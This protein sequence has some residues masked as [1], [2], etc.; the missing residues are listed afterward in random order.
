MADAAIRYGD[1]TAVGKLRPLLALLGDDRL[2]EQVRRGSHAA[3]E[4]LYERH[5]RG[6]LAFCRHM[7]GTAHDAEEA[8]QQ[9]FTAAY[10][11][12]TG[13]ARPEAPKPWLYG[14]ARHRCLAIL[15]RRRTDAGARSAM[16]VVTPPL[17][18]EVERR[19][20]M[21]DLLTGVSRLPE[22]QR[23][24]LVLFGLCGHPQADVA[25]VIGCDEP[26]VRALVYQARSSL[27]E[28]RRARETP[29]HEVREKL[30]L[31][32]G[33]ALRRRS[34]RR[35]VKFCPGCAE[36]RAE[37]LRQR[38]LMGLT[39]PPVPSMALKA[40]VLAAAG[41]AASAGGGGGTSIGL[42]GSLGLAKVVTA[43]LM[44]TATPVGGGILLHDHRPSHVPVPRPP[45]PTARVADTAPASAPRPDRVAIGDPVSPAPVSDHR[46]PPAGPRARKRAPRGTA[47]AALVP[48]S[49]VVAGPGSSWPAEPAAGEDGHG[50]S[51][52]P[53]AGAGHGGDS[54][55]QGDAAGAGGGGDGSPKAG[56][57]G[58]SK[59][60]RA[61]GSDGPRAAQPAGKGNG[62]RGGA[63][64]GQPSGGGDP[65]GGGDSS[66]GGG[67]GDS[68]GGDLSAQP[69]L[70]AVPGDGGAC[71]VPSDG[72]NGCD[73]P[74]AGRG[75]DGDRKHSLSGD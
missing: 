68:P 10:A 53:G 6:I 22:P 28:D 24:A 40:Q 43:A 72:G 60:A 56:D 48:P 2:V 63:Q 33:G 38:K 9:T 70:P 62:H 44:L 26:R 11:D 54:H 30:A 55:G 23:T 5:H 13:G 65:H 69:A 34:L 52:S 58:S 45:A 29:C 46:S 15:R 51:R 57:N 50:G 4:A 32:R 16:E 18:E 74:S 17:V 41:V 42:G 3:F 73:A 20:E 21:R 61:Q 66:G 59:K 64:D 1:A 39:P 75:L 7:L 19:T 47:P 12:L 67:H 37:V 49:P 71:P 35:H 14:V 27:L 25:A 36:F 8:V 31:G